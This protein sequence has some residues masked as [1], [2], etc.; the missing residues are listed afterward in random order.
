MFQDIEGGR[1][2]PPCFIQCRQWK[3]VQ[4]D[5]DVRLVREVNGGSFLNHGPRFLEFQF[6]RIGFAVTGSPDTL[7]DSGGSRAFGAVATGSN[8]FLR[9]CILAPPLQHQDPA[10]SA[11]ARKGK[12]CGFANNTQHALQSCSRGPNS[13]L[14]FGIDIHIRCKK[15]GIGLGLVLTRS[16][17]EPKN[18][19]G[20]RDE[21]ADPDNI[22]KFTRVVGC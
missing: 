18:I 5:A 11:W 3:T 7:Q 14:Q 12:E 8:P 1:D 6:I 9:D 20:A 10:R 22:D 4:I 2:V 15:I 17:P 21:K 16:H 13:D 19:R